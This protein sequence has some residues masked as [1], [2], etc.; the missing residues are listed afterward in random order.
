MVITLFDL[1]RADTPQIL[2]AELANWVAERLREALTRQGQA[3]LVV[4]G[5]STPVPFFEALSQQVLD[6]SQVHI[7]LADERWVAPEHADSNERLVRQHLLR[8]RAAEARFIPLKTPATSVALG[9]PDTQAALASL[10]WPA[11]VTVLGM[12]GDGHTASLFPQSAEWPDAWQTSHRCL[13]VGVPAL[14]NVQLE[15]ISLTPAALLDAEH[16]VLHCTG[17]A[18][19]PLIEKASQPGPIEALPV[20]LV[21]CQERVPVHVFYSGS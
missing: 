8:N 16:I 21:L 3:L 19:W 9:W 5:G 2:A 1:H 10:P 13:P 14:P 15:R 18:K 4:S 7:T 6:W 20:R 11:T 12:G 17:A